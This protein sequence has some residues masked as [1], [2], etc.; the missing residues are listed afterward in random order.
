MLGARGWGVVHALCQKH[1]EKHLLGRG[2]GVISTPP[3]SPTNNPNPTEHAQ[4]KHRFI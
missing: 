3:R 1:I 2:G 4:C